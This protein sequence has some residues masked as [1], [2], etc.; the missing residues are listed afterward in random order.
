M[1]FPARRILAF[2][3]DLWL[4]GAGLVLKSDHEPAIF[5]LLN[6]IAIRRAVVS[7]AELVREVRAEFW[8]E[9]RQDS[10]RVAP[11]EQGPIGTGKG[12]NA[13]ESFPVGS[14]ASNGFIERGIQS[15]EGQA[16]TIRVRLKHI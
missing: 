7:K 6:N 5:D 11:D 16:R 12:S 13:L 3:K 15:F 10:V 4:D 9:T 8:Y 2:V 1:E 14:P